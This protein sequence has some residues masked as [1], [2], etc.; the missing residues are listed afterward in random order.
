MAREEWLTMGSF[1]G[2]LPEDSI[3]ASLAQVDPL[4]L[5]RIVLVLEDKTRLAQVLDLAGAETLNGLR[6][7]A[8]EHGLDEQIAGLAEWLSAEQRVALSL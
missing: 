4:S 6:G 5:L 1:V 8:D 7:A 3:R 2:Q